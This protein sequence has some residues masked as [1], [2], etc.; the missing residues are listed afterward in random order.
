MKSFLE[1]S[2]CR[3]LPLETS[4]CRLCLCISQQKQKNYFVAQI[5]RHSRLCIYRFRL[6]HQ[7]Y[8]SEENVGSESVVQIK[9]KFVYVEIYRCVLAYCVQSFEFLSLLLLLILHT[10]SMLSFFAI[11]YMYTWRFFC[12]ILQTKPSTLNPKL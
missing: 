12:A 5:Q 6:M 2:G 8:K 3:T 1:S 7:W 11:A 10:G 9:Q 4:E